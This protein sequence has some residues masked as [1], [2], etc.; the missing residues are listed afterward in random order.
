MITTFALLVGL[1]APSTGKLIVTTSPSSASIFVDGQEANAKSGQAFTVPA[2]QRKVTVKASGHKDQTKSV[3]V[4][5]GGTARLTVT[6]SK[7]ST[8]KTLVPVKKRTSKKPTFKRPTTGTAGATTDGSKRPV[9]KKPVAKRPETKRPVAKRP[10][11]KT[12][13]KKTNTVKRKPKTVVAEK[14]RVGE[15][16]QP[17]VASK[18]NVT[19]KPVNTRPRAGGGGG[20]SGAAPEPAPARRTSTKPAA[21]FAFVVGGLAVTGGVLA[22]MQADGKAEDFNKSLDRREK[23]DLRDEAEG[24][25]LGSNIAYGVGATAIVVGAVLWAM[26]DSDG[27]AASVAPLPEGGAIVGLGGTF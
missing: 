19:R 23:M 15:K 6:L 3:L 18:P 12:P 16:P 24:W 5:K 13:I 26:D 8:R 25:A 4:K 21:I 2:G 11:K 7:A 22:G 17:R 9:S 27:Y 14:P 10:G 1:L 20:V